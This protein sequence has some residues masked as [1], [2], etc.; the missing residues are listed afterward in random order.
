MNSPETTPPELVSN[1]EMSQADALTIKSGIAGAVLMHRAGTHVAATAEALNLGPSP[2]LLLAGPGNNGGDAFVAATE[3]LHRGYP[4]ALH[5]LGTPNSLKG[6]AKMMADAFTDKG[7]IINEITTSGQSG[8][9]TDGLID[10]ISASDIIIDGLFGAGL[11]RPLEGPLLTLVNTINEQ[12][13]RPKP[14][15][16][17][18][19]DIPSGIHG[20]TGQIMGAAIKAHHTVTFCRPKPGHFLYPGRAHCGRLSVKDIGIPDRI[21]NQLAPKTALNAPPA[22]QAHLN[23][24][25]VDSHKYNNGAALIIAGDPQMLGATTLAANAAARAGAGL[26]TLAIPDGTATP[27]SLLTAIITAQTSQNQSWEDIVSSRKVTAALYGPGAQPNPQTR[28]Q[29]RDLASLPIGLVL[30]A[31][32]LSAFAD[33]ANE[34]STA[35]GERQ[36]PSILTPHEG[37]FARLFGDTVSKQGKLAAALQ[38][39]EKSKAIMVLKGADTVIAAPDGRALINH[40][41]PPTL[42]T[43]GTGDVLAGMITALLARG[44][45]AFEAAAAAVWLHGKAATFVGHSMVADDLVKEIP[46][47]LASLGD[48]H[49]KAG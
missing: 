26:V 47:A 32:A 45:P 13:S 3:L 37:E 29:V 39:A 28:D 15:L 44:L 7:G 49:N 38:A 25:A 9:L 48:A 33:H 41:A 30:D 36:N 1:D 43:A 5:A 22:W 35:L 8:T 14:P 2:V 12:A 42:A 24:R 10:A 16:I 27:A 19:I 18:A 6:D 31:G 46:L 20:D 4:V 21:I 34:L 40:N 23:G 17:V 11:D